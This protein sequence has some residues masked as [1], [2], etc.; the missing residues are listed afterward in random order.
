M[1]KV[2]YID[3]VDHLSGKICRHQETIFMHRADTGCNFTSRRCNPS[4]QQPSEAMLSTRTAF[5]STI[6]KVKT[7]ITDPVQYAAAK[8][9]FAKQTKY[10]TLRGFL[11]AQNYEAL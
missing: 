8:E 11:F 4:T 10:K 3:P 9:A 6:A 7:V 5:K 1:A 2:F